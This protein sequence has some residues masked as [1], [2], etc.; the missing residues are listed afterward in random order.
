[1]SDAMRRDRIFD[2]T[3]RHSQRRSQKHQPRHSRRVHRSREHVRKGSSQD[4]HQEVEGHVDDSKVKHQDLSS[5]STKSMIKNIRA[6]DVFIGNKY[7]GKGQDMTLKSS[8]QQPMDNYIEKVVCC[9]CCL[10]GYLSTSQK[11]IKDHLEREHF[12]ALVSSNIQNNFADWSIVAQKEQI[13]LRCPLC[14][15]TFH[16]VY[17]SFKVHLIDDHGL[18][19]TNTDAYF[20]A[21]NEMQVEIQVC[22]FTSERKY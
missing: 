10:C 19:E 3:Q 9:K 1:M 13:P 20:E 2:R 4:G 17:L 18:D 7:T 11:R 22:F 12:D 16:G 5:T 15:N 14:T 21:Q 8:K 6:P